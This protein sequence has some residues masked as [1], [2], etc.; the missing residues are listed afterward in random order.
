MTCDEVRKRVAEIADI[1]W[2]DERAHSMEDRLYVDIMRAIIAGASDPQ[3]LCY[4]ALKT[5]DL[6]FAR[7]CA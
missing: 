2:D 6:D 1:I 5:Q 3:S 4:E 7:W